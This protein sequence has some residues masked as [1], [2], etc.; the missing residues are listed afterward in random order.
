MNRDVIRQIAVVV[1]LIITLTAN[2]L[3][4]ALP[5]NG[6]TTAEISNRL[7]ILFVPENY[8][9]SIWGVIYT[10]L[11][12]YV[13]Y[14]ALP[15]Q[16][17]NPILRRIGWLFVVSCI[18]NATWIVAF[19]YNQFL[20]SFLLI[21][22]V[23]VSLIGV[24]IRAGIGTLAVNNKDKWMIHVPFS[25]YLAWLTV[26]TIANATYVLYDNNWDGFGISPETWAIV[27]LVIATG[28]VS[29]LILRTRD[30]A[31]TSVIV[32]AFIGIVVKQQD[33]VGVAVTAGVMTAVVIAV[34][35]AS[36]TFS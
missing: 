8:V 4:N 7:Q 33:Y 14:Q 17:E 19:H 2:G 16:R 12:I 36:R 20:L 18:A 11:I 1:S 35:F 32:W 26:A 24:Y 25:V 22:V 10:L 27:M 6:Q 21:V 31:Y 15:S 34:L 3:A 28:I 9:F 5:I 23:L 13:V 29:W 30:I